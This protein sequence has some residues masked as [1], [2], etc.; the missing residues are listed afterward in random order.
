VWYLRRWLALSW[1]I[2]EY[3]CQRPVSNYLRYAKHLAKKLFGK[4]FY[5]HCIH[6][7]IF[8]VPLP[9]PIFI[10]QQ[11]QGISHFV[12]PPSHWVFV[13]L[14]TPPLCYLCFYVYCIGCYWTKKFH[15]SCFNI[16]L[17]KVQFS[18]YPSL[19]LSHAQGHVS[20][21]IARH[22]FNSVS[23]LLVTSVSR[24]VRYTETLLNDYNYYYYYY[25]CA[26]HYISSSWIFLFVQLRYV[27]KHLQCVPTRYY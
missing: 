11:H 8:H 10:N 12:F 20:T 7:A 15:L 19:S 16:S 2:Y 5:M 27:A 24:I 22:N 1:Q 14:H 3:F 25:Y 18:L 21:A 23:L 4:Q 13:P 17:L 6:V 26:I 9:V